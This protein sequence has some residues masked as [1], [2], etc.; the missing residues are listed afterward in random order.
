MNE[1]IIAMSLGGS[2]VFPDGEP[3]AMFLKQFRKFV[4]EEIK[5]E[6]RK[7]LIVVGGGRLC[8]LYNE[9]A[10]KVTNV[11]QED[12][13]WLGI[14]VTRLNAQ[15]LRTIF[16]DVA[17][18]VVIHKP[19]EIKELKYPVTIGAGWKPG[20][21]TDLGTVQL[22]LSYGVKIVINSSKPTHVYDKDPSRYKNAKPLE[23]LT[24]KEYKKLIPQK[25]TPGANLPFDPIATKFAEKEKMTVI[26][27][28]GQNLSNLKSLLH[29]KPFIGTTI[30][31]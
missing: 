23:K 15:L 8:R 27:L 17:D 24:W 25:W 19:G 13:D 9:V 7:F 20:N 6:G 29:N 16:Y 12:K 28:N 22:A 14:H 18:P 21:S 1:K 2:I 31:P 5:K 26:I 10:S 3:D 11:T 4:L 30:S